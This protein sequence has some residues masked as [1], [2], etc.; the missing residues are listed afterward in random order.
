MI[1]IVVRVDNANMAANV[2]GSVETTFRT[3][4]VDIPALEAFLRAA[5]GRYS[6]ANVLG[7]ELLDDDLPET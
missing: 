5:Q 2:G 6:H 7:I 4:D 1:R 3:F